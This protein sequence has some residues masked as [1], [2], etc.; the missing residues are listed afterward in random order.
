MSKSWWGLLL[1][2]DEMGALLE[3]WW[4]DEAEARR[5]MYRAPTPRERAWKVL[6]QADQPPGASQAAPPRR[7]SNKSGRINRQRPIRRHPHPPETQKGNGKV[8]QTNVAEVG[9]M[10]QAIEDENT[11][12]IF[13]RN[14]HRGYKYEL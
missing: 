6:N 9:Y 13:L 8:G 11:H 5:R 4:I 3:R 7:A 14:R 1:G 2:M 10:G 12:P